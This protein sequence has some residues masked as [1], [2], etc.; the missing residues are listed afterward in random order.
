MRTNY[1]QEFFKCQ[2]NF[3]YIDTKS[4]VRLEVALSSIEYFEKT[5]RVNYAIRICLDFSVS[6]QMQVGILLYLA[7]I[8]TRI[9]TVS[10]RPTLPITFAQCVPLKS[11]TGFILLELSATL[12]DN[13]N[14][15]LFSRFIY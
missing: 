6:T 9:H 13:Q 10:A 15:L 4:R 5:N 8:D 11:L 3:S 2:F 7:F 12:T 14:M 1:F